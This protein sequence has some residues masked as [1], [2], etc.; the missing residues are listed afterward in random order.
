MKKSMYF[1]KISRE[2]Y[3]EALCCMRH[4]NAPSYDVTGKEAQTGVKSV[5]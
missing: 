3:P 5:M 4:Q 1:E 2:N